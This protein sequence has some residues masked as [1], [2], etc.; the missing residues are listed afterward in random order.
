VTHRR[1]GYRTART[2]CAIWQSLDTLDRLNLVCRMHP[3]RFGSIRSVQLSGPCPN[4]PYSEITDGVDVSSM[5]APNDPP[6]RYARWP[7]S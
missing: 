2:V 7:Y 5:E 3:T 6:T 1:S 4:C